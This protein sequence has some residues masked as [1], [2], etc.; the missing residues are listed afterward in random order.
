MT[1]L[2]AWAHGQA[3]D[4]LGGPLPRRW[5]HVQGVAKQARKA[6]LLFDPADHELLE[7]AAILH[8]VGY[9]PVIS[10]TGFTR[11]MVRGISGGGH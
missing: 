4:L 7:M 3:E 11:W 10:H 2:V 6:T 5:A 1:D 8:D 9:S